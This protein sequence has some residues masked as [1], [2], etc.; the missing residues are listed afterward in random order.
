[1]S[2]VNFQD[3]KCPKKTVSIQGSFGAA[4]YDIFSNPKEGDVIGN[5]IPGSPSF[6]S[7][8]NLNS[9]FFEDLKYEILNIKN[10][11]S[12]STLFVNPF[13]LDLG[14]T[15]SLLRTKW[16][17]IKGM[18]LRATSRSRVL[19]ANP[20]I[21]NG[22]K[23]FHTNL[24]EIHGEVLL[25]AAVN[26]KESIGP[27]LKF[28]SDNQ[29]EEEKNRISFINLMNLVLLVSA[30]TPILEKVPDV[31][32]GR[33]PLPAVNFNSNYRV[34]G[35]NFAVRP[36]KGNEGSSTDGNSLL[37]LVNVHTEIPG[38]IYCLS[39]IFV[40]ASYPNG[41]VIY[42]F[43]FN[44]DRFFPD[45][46]EESTYKIPMYYSSGIPYLGMKKIFDLVGLSLSPMGTVSA[47]I[48]YSQQQHQV[49][50]NGFLA[51]MFSIPFDRINRGADEFF[52]GLVSTQKELFSQG[53]RLVAEENPSN[54]KLKLFY[55]LWERPASGFSFEKEIEK[56][57]A[58]ITKKI[59]EDVGFRKKIL[60]SF[61][62][63]PPPSFDSKLRGVRFPVK[64][65]I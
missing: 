53:L 14:T 6:W 45:E 33:V 44:K 21:I 5:E 7:K 29:T 60:A 25:P 4:A 35:P 62:V 3:I 40:P 61:E 15:H 51:E 57:R 39:Y 34:F 48:G 20:L 1:M 30:T 64:I 54:E 10:T 26:F 65:R 22:S 27:K 12:I 46:A 16:H 63:K 31:A 38:Q 32:T 55:Y 47:N 13:G 56:W 36:K 52:N 42:H 58:N 8:F 9:S 17:E 11:H 50:L 28:S 19:L 18:N 24:P 43:W 2:A 23:S 59:Q 49:P 41:S 37:K